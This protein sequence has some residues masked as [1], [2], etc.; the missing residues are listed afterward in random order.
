MTLSPLGRG[1]IRPVELDVKI[2]M[3]ARDGV[4]ICFHWA[5]TEDMFV[6]TATKATAKLRW[7]VTDTVARGRRGGWML[8]VGLDRRARRKF[9]VRVALHGRF[10]GGD[11]RS[12]F[13]DMIGRPARSGKLTK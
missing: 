12:D 5:G 6:T 13:G 4:R 2:A 9:V 1:P 11:V 3:E 7:V 8:I 10:G